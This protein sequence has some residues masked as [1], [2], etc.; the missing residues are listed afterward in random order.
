MGPKSGPRTGSMR[1]AYELFGL[2]MTAR[3][4]AVKYSSPDT[5]PD[6]RMM[7]EFQNTASRAGGVPWLLSGLLASY[8]GIT[9]DQKAAEE[10]MSR[11]FIA[12]DIRLLDDLFRIA[13]FLPGSDMRW[14]LEC[15]QELAGDTLR[16]T[17]PESVQKLRSA[18]IWDT[19]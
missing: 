17:D 5:M 6:R 14:F 12:S 15:L 18:T 1:R 9:V 7:A 2:A 8:T 13:D 10:A 11:E 4:V 19:H 16:P 3:S